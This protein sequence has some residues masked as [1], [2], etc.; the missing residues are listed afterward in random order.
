MLTPADADTIAGTFGLGDVVRF[1]G[2][3]ARGVIGQIWR[4]GTSSGIWAV[5]EWFGRPDVDELEEGTAFHEAAM[6]VGVP[7]PP[8][9]RTPDGRLWIEV[10][11]TT[12][13]VQ[14][15]VDLNDRDPMLDPSEVGRL[16]GALHQ[17][18]FEGRQPVD[19]WYAE[20]VGRDR[21][22]E[23]TEALTQA[24]APFVD[25]LASSI[26][27]LVALDAL[28]VPPRD[29]RTCHRDL[30]ADNLRL[31]RAGG[32]CL[33]DWEDCG[34]ADPSMEL[35]LVVW[36]FGRTDPERARAIHAA[37]DAVGGPGRVRQASDFS[38][39]IAQLGHIG[40]RACADWLQ[41]SASDDERAFAAEWFGEFIDEPLTRETI[42][43]LFEA[44]QA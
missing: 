37:Y 31:T 22:E 14:G 19:A 9:V 41:P 1:A 32:L 44:V 7:A 4:L 21:W 3:V 17:V 30:W 35:A 27:E 10:G 11:G 8:V 38:M 15:W 34:L 36:E 28:V 26:D 24:N 13:R 42:A 12:T 29:L 39:A 6:G 5:K 2:P 18:P 33:I 23:L 43:M 20:P 25:R 16:V 40:A